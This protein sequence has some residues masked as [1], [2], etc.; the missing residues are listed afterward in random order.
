MGRDQALLGNLDPVRT[1]RNG[2]P[3]SVMAALA[4]CHQQAGER[5]IVG[6]GCEVPRDTPLENVRALTEYAR[7]PAGGHRSSGA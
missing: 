4:A 1:L 6:A 2:T 3:E 7:S 5:Y